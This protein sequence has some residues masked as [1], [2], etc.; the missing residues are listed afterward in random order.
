MAIFIGHRVSNKVLEKHIRVYL[1]SYI[2]AFD[3]SFVRWYSLFMFPSSKIKTALVLYSGGR[4]S[5]ATAL[6]MARLGYMVKLFT[7]QWGLSELVGPRGD[8]APDIRHAELMGAFPK[9]IDPDRAIMGNPYLVRKLAIEKTNETH[10]VYPIALA[11]AV[12]VDAILYCM[13]RDI[14]HIACG[15][16][17][18]QATRDIYIEQR[19]DF[20]LLMKEFVG[21]Y[22]I[23]YHTPVIKKNKT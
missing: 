15:Y 13:K 8:S 9:Y 11:L 16:S 18:Y 7:C 23:E 19:E 22:G 6:E 14:K 17:G 10:V 20:L 2:Q 5:S 1:H 4:D 12:H 21:E 3:A